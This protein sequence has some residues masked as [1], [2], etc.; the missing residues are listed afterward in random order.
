MRPKKLAQ[1]GEGPSVSGESEPTPVSVLEKP[2]VAES[3]V[4]MPVMDELV[5]TAPADVGESEVAVPAAVEES[6][7]AVTEAAVPAD[8]EES[9]VAVPADVEEP[10]VT[11]S[12]SGSES[13]DSSTT[14]GEDSESAG[15]DSEDSGPAEE[16]AAPVVEDDSWYHRILEF[17]HLEA[18]GEAATPPDFTRVHIP[19]TRCRPRVRVGMRLGPSLR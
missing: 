12:S 8:V 16:A 2:K 3:G 7:A 15:S 10:R 13:S 9:E 11:S 4:V 17:V 19:L 5:V 1:K 18:E 14:L 6:E